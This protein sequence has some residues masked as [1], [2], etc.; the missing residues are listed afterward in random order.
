LTL[1]HR[2][3][4]PDINWDING[5]HWTYD[6]ALLRSHPTPLP[7]RGSSA[8][9]NMLQPYTELAFTTDTAD[10][11]VSC[12]FYCRSIGSSFTLV[13]HRSALRRKYNS[14][15]G[16]RQMPGSLVDLQEPSVPWSEW[17]P[18]NTRWVNAEPSQRWICYVHGHR[19]AVLEAKPNQGDGRSSATLYDSDEDDEQT[20]Q[21]R[22]ALIKAHL[23]HIQLGGSSS[24]YSHMSPADQTLFI[25]D[26][27]D[28]GYQYLRVFDF[29]PRS[30]R[31]AL[32]EGRLPVGKPDIGC[33]RRAIQ[34]QILVKDPSVL[35]E[36]IS[37]NLPYLET[38]V[39]LRDIGLSGKKRQIEG[40][41][42]N[43]ET[44]MIMMSHSSWTD[45]VEVLTV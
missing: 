28:T 44:I 45:G 19:L 4:L 24:D 20:H 39:R 2:L 12:N 25:S 14:V 6:E 40:V 5:R 15:V 3:E 31:R 23:A 33:K 9:S 27:E 17:G 36:R 43:A 38:T 30:V 26:N 16:T 1:F 11:V 34:G 13:V 22:L 37:T 18:E 41:M 29:N 21:R 10:G 42:M 8:T 35:Q 32:V 7:E